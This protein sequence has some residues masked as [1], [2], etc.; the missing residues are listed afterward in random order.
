[1]RA[2]WTSCPS[3]G[4]ATSSCSPGH[5]VCRLRRGGGLLPSPAGPSTSALDSPRLVLTQTLGTV[6]LKHSLPLPSTMSP[7]PCFLPATLAMCPKSLLGSMALVSIYVFPPADD[8]DISVSW[9]PCPQL[10]L[11]ADY[12]HLDA[13]WPFRCI[14]SHRELTVS[15]TVAQIATSGV[16]LNS[17]FSPSPPCP[18]SFC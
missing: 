9:G 4:E 1:M 2:P 6:L 13:P 14:V 16:A 3:P 15:P 5:P 7:A 10:Q 17:S 11:P 12:C 8:C 18:A